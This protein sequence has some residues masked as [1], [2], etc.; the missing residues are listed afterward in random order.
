MQD[1]RATSWSSFWVVT[2][3]QYD[4]MPLYNGTV[5]DSIAV[6]CSALQKQQRNSQ[7]CPQ[8]DSL[9]QLRRLG[10]CRGIVRVV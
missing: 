9:Q 6:Q 10:E 8:Y 5:H 3:Q 1:H 2:F 4:A 7:N